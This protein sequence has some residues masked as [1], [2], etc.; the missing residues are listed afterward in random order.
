MRS[1]ASVVAAAVLLAG[2]LAA[3]A[4]AQLAAQDEDVPFVVPLSA[5]T[6]ATDTALLATA[7][8]LAHARLGWSQWQL[9][10]AGDREEA[11]E[12][13]RA[14]MGAAGIGAFLL[15]ASPAFGSLALRE[16]LIVESAA[17]G[18]LALEQVGFVRDGEP[19]I[20]PFDLPRLLKKTR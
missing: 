5:A 14:I 13:G 2:A 9:A 1:W 19:A 17:W 8:W 10:Q 3:P 6:F 12:Q 20:D 4:Q 18:V 16:A 7:P 11:L 15:V